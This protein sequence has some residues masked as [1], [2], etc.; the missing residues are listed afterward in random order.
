MSREFWTPKPGDTI[1]FL[2]PPPQPKG[3]PWGDLQEAMQRPAPLSPH[4]HPDIVLE[5]DAQ[6]IAKLR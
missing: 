3:N 4:P 2:D 1:R 5:T 6:M